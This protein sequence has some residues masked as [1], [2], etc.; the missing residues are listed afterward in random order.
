MEDTYLS[1]YLISFLFFL[2]SDNHR[3]HCLLSFCI[4]CTIYKSRLWFLNFLITTEEQGLEAS[5]SYPCVVLYIMYRIR[6]KQALKMRHWTFYSKWSVGLTHLWTASAVEI[7]L[8]SGCI[9][10]GACSLG[11]ICAALLFAGP[12]SAEFWG[13]TSEMSRLLFFLLLHTP[14]SLHELV[15]KS[16]LKQTTSVLFHIALTKH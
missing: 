7:C 15:L 12:G 1:R 14:T 9:F 11:R 4:F 13:P 8:L 10:S 6:V 5:S 3:R 2:F 16:S